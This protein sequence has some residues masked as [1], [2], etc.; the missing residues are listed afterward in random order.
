[1]DEVWGWLIGLFLVLAAVALVIDGIVWVVINLWW[2]VL[3]L[4]SA[5]LLW[6]ICRHP[7]VRAKRDL[8]A[9][10]RRGEEVRDEIERATEESEAEMDR[11]ARDWNTR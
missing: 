3:L 8:R 1:M 10:V 2:V 4:A 6:L 5:A 11:I 9:I 7:G